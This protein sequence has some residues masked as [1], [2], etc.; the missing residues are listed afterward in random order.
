MTVRILLVAAL[1][2]AA[3]GGSKKTVKKPVVGPATEPTTAPATEPTPP[4]PPPPP[5]DPCASLTGDLPDVDTF[6]AVAAP[7]EGAAPKWVFTRTSSNAS[8]ADQPTSWCEARM[9]DTAIE[10]LC[11]VKKAGVGECKSGKIEDAAQVK[12][13]EDALKAVKWAK[14]PK[15]GKQP[16]GAASYAYAHQ[17]DKAATKTHTFAPHKQLVAVDTALGWPAP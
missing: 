14:L 7:A 1:L 4:P 8:A 17:T 6:A 10:W 12:A 11:E 9:V 13:V 2:C 16:A 15:P 5:P 3:C